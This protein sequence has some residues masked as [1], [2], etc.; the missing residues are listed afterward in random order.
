[1]KTWKVGDHIELPEHDGMASKWIEKILWRPNNKGYTF[2][3]K[4]E[5]LDPAKEWCII[6]FN[7]GTWENGSTLKHATKK[8]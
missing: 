2:Y 1:M 7:D 8:S 5:I 4:L 6:L 3:E